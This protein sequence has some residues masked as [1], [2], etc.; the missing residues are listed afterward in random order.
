MPEIQLPLALSVG[1]PSG[2]GPEIAIAAWQARDSAGVPPFYLLADPALVSARARRL[3][4]DMPITETMPAE[5]ARVFTRALP[6]VPLVARFVDDPGRPDTA[7]AAGIIEAID[8][9]VDDCL[10]GRAAAVVTCPIAKKP[11]YDAGF[12]F[13]G[14][15]EYLA[16]LATLHTGAEAMPVMMLAGP[17]LRT[18]PVTI[19]IALS[20]VPKA[21]TT[22]LIVATA[23]ITA[24]DLEHRFG[25]AKPRLA[26]AGLNPH[27][28]EGG[29]MG[30][31]DEHIIRPAIDRLRAEGI[32]AFG[33]LPAD[34]LFHARARTG[35]DVAL[36]MYHDQALI[37]AKAL[38]FDEAVNVTLGLPFIRTSPDHGTAFDIAGKGIA[39]ADSLIAALRLARRLA[40][41][42]TKAAI[43]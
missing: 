10:G 36:C 8:R 37:P 29:A 11:L 19:H 4:A 33:P 25:I 38:A 43:A 41:T 31:E 34:T 20:E 28:G 12:R 15:T 23:R 24:A 26:I 13:P 5:A 14:H 6:V 35:Y 42:G 1:D 30:A 27:A 9:A 7:N 16:H 40:D 39:R 32:D 21:L 2:I 17:E 22:D 3:V 18:V